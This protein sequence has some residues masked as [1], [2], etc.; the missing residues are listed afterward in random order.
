MVT[1]VS[2]LQQELVAGQLDG[3]ALGDLNVVAAFLNTTV[4]SIG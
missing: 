4:K 1:L 2:A 3:V